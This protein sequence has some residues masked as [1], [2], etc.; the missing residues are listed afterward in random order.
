MFSL[1]VQ[2]ISELAE[3]LKA[4]KGDTFPQLYEATAEPQY[5]IAKS[6]LKDSNLAEDAIQTVYM[7]VYQ[8]ISGLAST[9]HFLPWLS[10]I[11]YNTCINM[12]K[13]NK[14]SCADL[15][16]E[17]LSS[18][19]DKHPD[20][21]PLPSLIQREN[22]QLLLKCLDGL[23][24]EHR[25]ILILRYYQDLKVREIADIMG[26]SEGTAKSRIHYA[27]RKLKYILK[28]MG[29]HGP[30]AFWGAGIFL[31][32][33]FASPGKGGLA[34]RLPSRQQIHDSIKVTAVSFMAGMF[35]IGAAHKL[36]VEELGD[37]RIADK[38]LFTKDYVTVNVTASL[39]EK[40]HL[41]AFY[42][43][44][45]ELKISRTDGSHYRFQAQRNGTIN[46]LLNNGQSSIGQKK[47]EI[48][49]IDRQAPQVSRT[50]NDGRI[51]RV[52]LNDDLSGVDYKKVKA[53]TGSRT[54]TV[55]RAVSDQSF[56]EFVLPEKGKMD[57]TVTDLAGNRETIRLNTID[58][59]SKY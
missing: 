11:T 43:N 40:S 26:I 38:H 44:G 9:D 12:L 46:V 1:T 23:S 48:S 34:C 52:Y 47:I 24:L 42:K 3:S 55:L 59:L 27:L 28:D 18:R 30:D 21:N 37:V 22:H 17:A 32:S 13:A 49:Q 4:G 25:T 29:Y 57:L 50:V 10:R 35:L 7:K 31:R 45:E 14:K 36:P 54:L 8:S 33:S 6:M 53:R 41:R 5:F 19:P 51:L 58:R 20:S 16:E 2:E 15:D 56:V 39:K